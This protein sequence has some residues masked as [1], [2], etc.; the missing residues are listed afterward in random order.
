MRRQFVFSAAAIVATSAVRP[1][2][3][4]Q[5]LL[6]RKIGVL[7]A[8]PF[9]SD[10]WEAFRTGL[11]ELGYVEGKNL[12]ILWRNAEGKYERYQPLAQDLVDAGVEV[13]VTHSNPAVVAAQKVTTNV[14]IVA[15]AFSD[16]VLAGVVKSLARPGG[17]VTGISIVTDQTL[18]KLV[19]FALAMLPKMSAAAIVANPD[20]S[21][22]HDQMK[23]LEQAFRSFK[24]RTVPV[25]ARSADELESGFALMSRER[26]NAALFFVEPFLA[27]RKDQIAQL[28]LRRKIPTLTQSQ[29][30][31]EAGCL[32]SY[33]TYLPAHFHRA[34]AYVDKILKGTK[35]GDLP[36]EQ[37][38]RFE[39]VVN[40]KTAKI[41]GVTI[42]QSILLRA[43]KIIE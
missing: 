21:R 34:A 19:E 9:T 41:L 15:A 38:T 29:E 27:S 14:P 33:G 32:L 26:V 36:I 25:W 8:L 42:P 10:R 7:T 22:A 16:P 12:N 40:A 37:S 18:F 23:D 11:Q 43:D 1:F 39:L 20:A 13:I 24:V 28:G 4:A 31:P 30:F 6:V 17:N 3:F 35:P 5:T 2:A